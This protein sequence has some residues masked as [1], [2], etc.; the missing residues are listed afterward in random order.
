MIDYNWASIR[1]DDGEYIVIGFYG[2]VPPCPEI[3]ILKKNIGSLTETA[4]EISRLVR[5]EQGKKENESLANL[6]DMLMRENIKK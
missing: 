2:M 1:S 3:K 5:I 6:A 4:K